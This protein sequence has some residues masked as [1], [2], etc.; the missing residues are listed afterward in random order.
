MGEGAH[1][2]GCQLCDEEGALGDLHVEAKL[3][4]GAVVHGLAEGGVGVEL[5]VRECQLAGRWNSVGRHR[6][7]KMSM[8]M[9]FPGSRYPEMISPSTVNTLALRF[10][11][12]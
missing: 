4:V 6:T 3:H 12:A 10:A 11:T 1:D 8:T 5:G 9:G 2:A 7:L